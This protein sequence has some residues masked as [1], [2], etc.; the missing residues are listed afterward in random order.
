MR[1]LAV[2]LTLLT[3]FLGT[4]D[5]QTYRIQPGDTLGIVVWQDE[6]LNRDVLVG[7]DGMISF[8]LAGRIR[9]GGATVEAVEKALARGLK[10]LYT[11]ELD[12]SVAIRSLAQEEEET[13]RVIYVT[14][15]VKAPGKFEI[16]TPT[17]VLQAIALSG[18]VT[19]FAAQRR[20]QVIRKIKQREVVYTFNYSKYER[21]KDLEGN[22]YLRA[23]DVVVI[24]EGGLFE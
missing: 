19:E 4:A 10:K 15:E 20:I 13:G 6:K 17:T 2:F 9:A 14:G 16:K 5:A 8:P 23:G 3:L 1:R 21:G 18:G 11:T 12:V 7:P 24:P 22:I